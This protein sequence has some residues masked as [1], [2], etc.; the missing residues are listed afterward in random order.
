MY[1]KSGTPAH[2]STA[3]LQPGANFEGLLAA[4]PSAILGMDRDGVIQ[5]V[6]RRAA[7][8]FGYD[9][10]DLVGQPIQTVVPESFPKVHYARGAGSLADPTSPTMGADLEMTGR[11][12]DGSQFSVEI[13]L[14]HIGAGD[15]MFVI[16][17]VRDMT[18]GNEAEEGRR[19]SERALAAI[20]FS[21]D[22]IIIGTLDGLI[23]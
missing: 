12:R 8:I 15:E 21:G 19:Q 3:L 4:V 23:T 11:R 16:A 2:R 18:A 5:F 7:S 14:S 1:S 10:D 22:A 13:S 6:N 9:G 17:A 20:E